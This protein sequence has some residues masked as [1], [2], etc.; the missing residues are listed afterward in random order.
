MSDDLTAIADAVRDLTQP[1]T[2]IEPYAVV[3]GKGRVRPKHHLTKHPSLLD[4]LRAAETAGH[5]NED[6]PAGGYESRPAA[7]LEAIATLNAIDSEVA[8]WITWR[9]N[10]VRPTTEANLHA[11][12][13]V[14]ADLVLADRRE[15]AVEVR[16]WLTWARVV[17][18]W[19]S[20]PWRPNVPCPMCATKGGLRIRLIEEAAACLD[21]GAAWDRDSIGLL[22]EEIRQAT[23]GKG[24]LNR[25]A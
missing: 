7:R 19:D 2:H 1:Y 12:V 15:L 23:E 20:P 18:G 10:T 13:G 17:T 22:A 21:C 16:R 6:Q 25:S 14:A 11:I 9:R 8:T 5:G 3:D 4:Q 24:A